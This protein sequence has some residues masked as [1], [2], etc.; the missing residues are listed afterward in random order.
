MQ[1]LLVFASVRVIKVDIVL[2]V[3]GVVLHRMAFVGNKN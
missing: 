2:F 3:K 1:F